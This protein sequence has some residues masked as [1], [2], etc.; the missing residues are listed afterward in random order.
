MSK[1][2]E[3]TG[4]AYSWLSDKGHHLAAAGSGSLQRLAERLELS[5]APHKASEPA[6]GCGLQPRTY[7]TRARDLIDF[8]R[9]AQTPSH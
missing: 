2:P 3:Q 6:C 5:G 8:N 9:I 4:L 1:L 7:R